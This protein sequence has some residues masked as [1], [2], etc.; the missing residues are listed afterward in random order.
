[1]EERGGTWEGPSRNNRL[2]ERVIYS[3][4]GHG[5]EMTNKGSCQEVLMVVPGDW[6]ESLVTSSSSSLFLEGRQLPFSRRLPFFPS[7]RFVS[8]V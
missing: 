1:M 6:W 7:E 5:D 3:E 2:I 8:H 4:W